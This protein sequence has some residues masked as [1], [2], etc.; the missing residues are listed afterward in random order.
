SLTNTLSS[1]LIARGI[2]IN[3]VS[4]CPKDTPLYDKLGITDSYRKKVNEEIVKSIPS[5]RFGTAEEI[6]KAV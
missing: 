6:D 4:P 2:R 3:A 5:G 1:E